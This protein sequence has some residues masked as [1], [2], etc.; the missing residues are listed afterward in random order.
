MPS[1]GE[2]LSHVDYNFPK[3]KNN[4]WHSRQE[5]KHAQQCFSLPA[6]CSRGSSPSHRVIKV[7]LFS[8]DSGSFYIKVFEF[9]QTLPHSA[10]SIMFQ[11][12]RIDLQSVT[13]M[14]WQPSCSSH[15]Y[16]DMNALKWYYSYQYVLFRLSTGSVQLES[17]QSIGEIHVKLNIQLENNQI[18]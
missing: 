8:K 11:E 7:T 14:Q 15:D 12:W 2:G 4:L 3:I 9:I 17:T 16:G 10:Q 6:T 13:S 18:K 1:L 5:E